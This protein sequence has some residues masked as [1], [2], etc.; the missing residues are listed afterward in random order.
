MTIQSFVA[1]SVCRLI[2]ICLRVVVSVALSRPGMSHVIPS[3]PRPDGAK[4]HGNNE[5]GVINVIGLDC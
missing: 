2:H 1:I 5:N 4:S 3:K